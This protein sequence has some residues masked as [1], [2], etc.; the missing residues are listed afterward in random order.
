[1]L[2]CVYQF[3]DKCNWIGLLPLG[4]EKTANVWIHQYDNELYGVTLKPIPA[5]T[6]LRLGYSKEY[7]EKYGI[8]GPTMDIFA[9]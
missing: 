3:A 6:P 5:S 4:D 2:F 8:K 9:G 7:A 1:M